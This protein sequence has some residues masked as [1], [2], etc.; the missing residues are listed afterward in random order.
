M[1]T[2]VVWDMNPFFKPI[3]GCW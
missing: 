1:Q 2:T 3:Q